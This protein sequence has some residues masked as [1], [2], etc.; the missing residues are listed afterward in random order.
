MLSC[1]QLIFL[2]LVKLSDCSLVT[3]YMKHND[4]TNI[5]CELS[6]QIKNELFNVRYNSISI[7]NIK[8]KID[9]DENEHFYILMNKCNM[10]EIEKIFV[11]NKLYI[12][13]SYCNY[14]CCL[15]DVY[16]NKSKSCNNNNINNN[17]INNIRSLL[18][19]NATTITTQ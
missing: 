14:E 5:S 3:L 18:S 19:I 6:L 16:K 1:V 9:K 8:I 12:I 4:D 11:G 10:Y 17:N 7:Y 15:F 13:N 2:F